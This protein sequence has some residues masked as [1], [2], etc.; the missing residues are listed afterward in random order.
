MF[1][2]AD[3]LLVEEHEGKF[4]L[5]ALAF[6]WDG[7]EPH[8]DCYDLG[9][10]Q[11]VEFD[12]GEVKF[13]IGKRKTCIGQWDGDR[14][15]PCPTQTPVTRFD[16]CPKCAGESFIPDQ[17]C[18]F[19]PKCDG[20]KCDWDFC[21]REH[22]LYVAFYD[23]RMKIGMS[24]TRRVDRRLIEQG[25]DAYSIIG[26]FGSRRKAR[27]AEKTL[28]SRLKIPQSY[29]QEILLKN[30]VRPVDSKEIES[31][32]ESLKNASDPCCHPEPLVWLDKY[33][34]DLPLRETPKLLESWGSH[35]G[36]LVGIKGK[37]LIFESDG[38]KALSLPDVP[39]RFLARSI[40]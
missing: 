39:A 3:Q 18:L 13:M 16:Q 5:H 35:S 17:A 34:I 6:H 11:E 21:K 1:S 22:V 36:Q 25:A 37:W 12:L 24:S 28:S 40:I 31:L 7:Y 9:E 20:E 27:E 2:R 15:A 38:L 32:H 30:L 19:E 26:K 8:L 10:R 14:Y 33:P 4:P 23:I 29:R